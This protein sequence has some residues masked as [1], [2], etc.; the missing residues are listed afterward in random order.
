MLLSHRIVTRHHQDAGVDTVHSGV[1]A[2]ANKNAP[3]LMLD[4]RSGAVDLELALRALH[5]R[6]HIDAEDMMRLERALDSIQRAINHKL[7]YA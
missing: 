5:R 7:D 6:G 2:G 4:A 1:A 3:A